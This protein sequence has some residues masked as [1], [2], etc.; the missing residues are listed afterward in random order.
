MGQGGGDIQATEPDAAVPV[1]GELADRDPL[2]ASARGAHCSLS[3]VL[4]ARRKSDAALVIARQESDEAQPS[5]MRSDPSLRSL[6]ADPR[7]D[8]LLCKVK[9]L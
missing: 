7:F 3:E 1:F 5:L 6:R 9:V 8:A 2:D 4:L